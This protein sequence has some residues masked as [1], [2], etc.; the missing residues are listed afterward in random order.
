[1]Y[2]QVPRGTFLEGRLSLVLDELGM[3][4]VA[5]LFLV[6]GLLHVLV[7]RRDQAGASWEKVLVVLETA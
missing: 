5:L 4:Q 2:C 7:T 3:L 1:M 6:I